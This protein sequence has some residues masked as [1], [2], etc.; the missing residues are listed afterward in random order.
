LRWRQ[1]PNRPSGHA[2]ATV[3]AALHFA[4]TLDAA[5]AIRAAIAYDEDN[6][7]AV[8]TGA[9]VGARYGRRALNAVSLLG[10][11]VSA[12]ARLTALKIGQAWS[13]PTIQH[14]IDGPPT[15]CWPASGGFGPSFTP[16]V[17]LA[18]EESR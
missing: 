10:E 13:T 3:V 12:Q 15:Q 2:P 7:A 6:Y 14:D 18:P 4:S 8:L 5:R 9:F 16:S 1:P 17:P 11:T